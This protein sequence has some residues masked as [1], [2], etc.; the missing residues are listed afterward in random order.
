MD[1]KNAFLHGELKEE[2]YMKLPP[3][4]EGS[5][6]RFDTTT[7]GKYSSGNSASSK[8][9]RL[10]KTLYGL[11][12]APREWFDKLSSVLKKVDFVQSKADSSLFTKQ[13]DGTI[14]VILAYVDDLIVTGNDL[15]AMEKAKEFLKSQ[16]NMKDLGDLRYF[17]GIE[18]DRTEHGIFLSQRKYV[19]DLLREYNLLHCRPLKLPMDTHLKLLANSGDPLPHPE[20][21][22]RLVGK[23]IYLTITRQDIA[24]TVQV[25]SQSMHNPS[26]V[27]FQAAKRVLRYLAGS[28]EQ[29]ILLASQSTAHL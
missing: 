22:Q 26:T 14:V 23:L 9:C 8:V 15:Q 17:L 6:F 28:K 29:G 3:G 13:V 2:V 10:I 7:P 12:Q 11:K 5:G 21:Y 25:L 27:H 24:F 20:D 4:N 1:V 19:T 16:F 18:V